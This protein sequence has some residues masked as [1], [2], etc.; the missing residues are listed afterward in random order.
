[1]QPVCSNMAARRRD[2]VVL[3]W[4]RELLLI[5]VSGGR[6]GGRVRIRAF[7]GGSKTVTFFHQVPGL[8]KS[9][10]GRQEKLV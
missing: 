10:G 6:E 7:G 8:D 1:M 3:R 4:L 2:S 9:S 5:Y